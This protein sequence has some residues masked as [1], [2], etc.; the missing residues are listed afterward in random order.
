MFFN[1]F[2]FFLAVY[3]EQKEYDKCIE[4]CHKAIEIGRENRADFKLIAK[5]FSRIGNVYKK[6]E[7]IISYFVFNFNGH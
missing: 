2:F 1:L 7:V 3:F 5:A 4:Q 6:K